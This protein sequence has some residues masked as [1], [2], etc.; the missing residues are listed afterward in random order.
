MCVTGKVVASEVPR[1]SRMGAATAQPASRTKTGD[2][3][4]P[5]V[6]GPRSALTWMVASAAGVG[7]EMLWS[8]SNLE[9]ECMRT[10]VTAVGSPVA[11]GYR[12]GGDGFPQV[13]EVVTDVSEVVVGRLVED[14]NVCVV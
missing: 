9:T 8:A 10:K 1:V 3:W 7:E 11:C 13:D 12:R 6:D 5:S 4:L 2:Q 14:V